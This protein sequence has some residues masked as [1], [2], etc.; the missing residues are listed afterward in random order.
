MAGRH[1]YHRQSWRRKLGGRIRAV[2]MSKRHWCHT[3]R[4]CLTIWRLS[5]ALA[6]YIEN[7]RTNW[8]P[9]K[10]KGNNHSAPNSQHQNNTRNRNRSKDP[11]CAP[12]ASLPSVTHPTAPET[13][14]VKLT[15]STLSESER[16]KT[17][18]PNCSCSK[19]W[20]ETAT[21]Y[22]HRRWHAT[23][24]TWTWAIRR[25]SPR[26]PDRGKHGSTKHPKSTSNWVWTT[27]QRAPSRW[28]ERRRRMSRRSRRISILLLKP[29]SSP[30]LSHGSNLF[31]RSHQYCKIGQLL[32]RS[33]ERN[34]TMSRVYQ[35]WQSR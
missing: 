1:K 7:C 19:E 22:L 14:S 18:P 2:R 4:I 30:C 5:K 15:C 32:I 35:A 3:I 29:S 23:F 8:A 12:S 20:S 24:R 11:T 33:T 6:H 25:R 10:A 26:D 21:T 9:K 34:K 16:A 31:N 27:R 17:S 13:T 28:S